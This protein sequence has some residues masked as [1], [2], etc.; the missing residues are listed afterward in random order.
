VIGTVDTREPAVVKYEEPEAPQ[1]RTDGPNVQFVM[2]SSRIVTPMP[3]QRLDY[4]L[5]GKKPMFV[6]DGR[7]VDSHGNL[8]EGFHYDTDRREIVEGG[9]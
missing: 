8:V 5:P 7:V 6:V 4:V 2:D 3:K 1:A 9:G